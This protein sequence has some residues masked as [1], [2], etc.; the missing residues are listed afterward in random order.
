MC[1][2]KQR[3]AREDFKVCINN[4]YPDVKISHNIAHLFCWRVVR[5]LKISL[6]ILKCKSFPTPTKRWPSTDAGHSLPKNGNQVYDPNCNVYG[7]SMQHLRRWCSTLQ[8]V[9]KM[10]CSCLSCRRNLRVIDRGSN[11]GILQR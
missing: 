1:V 5:Q 6:L 3:R 8:M 7:H 10:S 2:K 9:V 11:C 4:I